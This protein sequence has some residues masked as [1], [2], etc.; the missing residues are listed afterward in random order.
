MLLAG[1]RPKTC[2]LESAATAIGAHKLYRTETY[3]SDGIIV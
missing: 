1:E 3:I 2:T